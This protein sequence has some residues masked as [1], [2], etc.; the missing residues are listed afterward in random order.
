MLLLFKQLKNMRPYMQSLIIIT[1]FYEPC[2]K[3]IFW[4]GR[5]ARLEKHQKHSSYTHFV[6]WILSVKLCNKIK[7]NLSAINWLYDVHATLINDNYRFQNGPTLGH[8][9]IKIVALRKVYSVVII[10]KLIVSSDW[11]WMLDTPALVAQ[12]LLNYLILKCDF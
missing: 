3:I 6:K 8:Q 7:S 11:N 4:V 1:D 2:N 12:K 10:T 9:G 5:F